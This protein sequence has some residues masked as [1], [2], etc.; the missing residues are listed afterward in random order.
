[1]GPTSQSS[2]T[3]IVMLHGDGQGRLNQRQIERWT[4]L[5][6]SLQAPDRTVFFLIRPGYQSPAG[7]SSGWA[8]PRDDDYT[9]QNME[10]VAGALRVLRDTFKPE[11]LIL[12]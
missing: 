6:R 3:L 11:K 12:A 10:R 2:K 4:V 8:N 5:G 9:S 1:M 7:N